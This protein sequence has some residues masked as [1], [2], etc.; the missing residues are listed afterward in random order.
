MKKIS[1]NLI[2]LDGNSFS[3]LGAFT[4]QAKK[5]KWNEEEIKEV[6]T[7]AMSGDY[8]HL[9]STLNTHCH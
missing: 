6:T 7:E 3:I 8:N 9:L 2:G 4:K 5:E 1:L